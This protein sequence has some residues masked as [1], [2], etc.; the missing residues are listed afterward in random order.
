MIGQLHLSIRLLSRCALLR[1]GKVSRRLARAQ[2]AI[3]LARSRKA[4]AG[5]GR[6]DRIRASGWQVRKLVRAVGECRRRS[7]S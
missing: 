3:P 6:L 1:G 4:V 2:A 5:L 7:G